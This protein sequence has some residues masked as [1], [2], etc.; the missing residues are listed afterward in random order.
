MT[1]SSG[2]GERDGTVGS[3]NVKTDLL[4]VMEA[5]QKL[6]TGQ[7][8]RVEMRIEA[9]LDLNPVLR[10]PGLLYEQLIQLCTH[11]QDAM[12]SGG[13]LVLRA[14]NVTV[15]DNPHTAARLEPGSYVRLQLEEYSSEGFGSCLQLNLPSACDQA[16]PDGKFRE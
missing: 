14:E 9:P 11:A 5:I 13:V 15:D 16:W 10:D 8:N 2:C 4:P 12:R 1:E 6:L 3:V 7:K